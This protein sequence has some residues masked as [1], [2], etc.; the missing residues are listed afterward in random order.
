MATCATTTTAT[1][2]DDPV[3]LVCKLCEETYQH[4]DGPLM[5][6]CLHSFCKPCLTKY[7]KNK[8]EPSVNNK[9]ACPTCNDWFPLPNDINQFPVNLRLSHLAKIIIIIILYS[10]SA[11][12][13]RT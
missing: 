11:E 3:S 9:M 1:A 13:L 8:Q 10:R 4:K 2:G 6:P 7:I 5:L 12:G